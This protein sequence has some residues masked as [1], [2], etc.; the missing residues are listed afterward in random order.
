[1]RYLVEEK[2]CFNPVKIHLN[3]HLCTD[4]NNYNLKISSS[5]DIAILKGG[6]ID[7]IS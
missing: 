7:G 4:K 6:E 1:M 3:N 2:Y 5:C